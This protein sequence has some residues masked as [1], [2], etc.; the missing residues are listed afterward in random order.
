L[1]ETKSSLLD[2]I[3]VFERHRISK[4]SSTTVSVVDKIDLTKE[5]VKKNKDKDEAKMSSSQSIETID[6]DS[7][8]IIEDKRTKNSNQK[9]AQLI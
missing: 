6:I 2:I 4:N 1:S 8:N 7:G 3:D 9:Y 5:K